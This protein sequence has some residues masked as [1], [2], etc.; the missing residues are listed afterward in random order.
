VV[1]PAQLTILAQNL[2]DLSDVGSGQLAAEMQAAEQMLA[3]A[4]DDAGRMLA[5]DAIAALKSLGSRAA[6]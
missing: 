6:A 2:L 3:S 5:Q 4:T 1:D